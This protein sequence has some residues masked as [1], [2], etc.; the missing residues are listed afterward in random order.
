[1]L[2][3]LFPLCRSLPTRRLDEQAQLLAAPPL[4][5]DAPVRSA[6]LREESRPVYP[7]SVIRGGVYSALELDRA[8]Q[9][10][11][12][13]AAHYA[14]FD[15][16]RVHTIRAEAGQPMYA[17]YRVRDRIYW[18]RNPVRLIAGETLLT[19]GDN[20]ARARCGNRLSLAPQQPIGREVNLASLDP[21][22]AAGVADGLEGFSE[23][24][25]V[26]EVFPEMLDNPAFRIA[27]SV[28]G[29]TAVVKPA[30]GGANSGFA[31]AVS[32]P[33]GG[34][35]IGSQ[36][37]IMAPQPG[38][39][40]SGGVPPASAEYWFMVP[41]PVWTGFING[42]TL[43]PIVAVLALP[44]GPNSVTLPSAPSGN[45][46]FPAPPGWSFGP[47]FGPVSPSGWS[48]PSMPSGA[49]LIPP[50]GPPPVTGSD[51]RH[52][53]ATD[54]PDPPTAVLFVCGGLLVAISCCR[55]K[56]TRNEQRT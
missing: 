28:P 48:P 30:A 44:P 10:D 27:D 17:S 35:G 6:I 32:L 53:V 5:S 34:I 7:Y 37:P 13:A 38:P 26:P 18:T 29:S 43:N 46:W 20:L 4:A 8:L 11:R 36:S 45:S 19:D 52:V 16:T 12:V 40:P 25:L 3:G 49:P 9:H 39:P 54:T 31:G 24:L 56:D 42:I 14:G 21:D 1:M 41:L 55:R 33:I 22:S 2:A 15:G 23:P 50:S 47:G 51:R